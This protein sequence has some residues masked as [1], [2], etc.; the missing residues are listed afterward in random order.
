[1][2]AYTDFL[3]GYDPTTNALVK[4]ALE[5]VQASGLSP[6]TLEQAGVRLFSGNADVLKDR[7]GRASIDG[8]PILK[9]SVLVEFPY[10]DKDGKV[11]LHEYKLI[12]SIQDKKYLHPMDTAAYP[13][14]LP[15]VWD[16]VDKPHKP[17]WITEGVKKVLKLI[18]HGRPCIGL[19]GVYN[20]K[21]G[22]NSE[23]TE[24]LSL[25]RELEAFNWKGRT[26]YIAFDSDLWTNPNVR[27]ALF[28]L[29]C[30][31]IARG[32]AVKIPIWKGEKGIDDLLTGEVSH[33]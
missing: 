33:G 7:L 12:P 29:A 19:S 13:Y 24:S 18:Q 26:V 17:L 30:T 10:Y 15:S 11:M 8:N 6:E 14:I 1:M 2:K 31:L 27:T 21:A 25:W 9:T 20:F 16:I 23:E 4:Q 22:R 32:A 28:T 5:D 3:N